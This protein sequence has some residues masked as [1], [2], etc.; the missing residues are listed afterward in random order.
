MPRLIDW[1][2]EQKKAHDKLLSEAVNAVRSAADVAKALQDELIELHSKAKKVTEAATGRKMSPKTPKPD[3]RA[4]F[5][6]LSKQGDEI[7][8]AQGR[9]L[10]ESQLRKHHEN[11]EAI[12][13]ALKSSSVRA[14]QI[15]KHLREIH[16]RFQKIMK[17]YS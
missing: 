6:S 5:Q 1:T 7:L 13:P 4:I 3:L 2:E 12:I 11:L 16:D 15:G 8:R 9:Q 10:T 17:M 14:Q